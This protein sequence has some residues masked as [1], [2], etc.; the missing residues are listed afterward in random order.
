MASQPTVFHRSTSSVEGATLGQ[1][2]Q[3]HQNGSANGKQKGGGGGGGIG[4][5]K[6][7]RQPTQDT[8]SEE[9]MRQLRIDKV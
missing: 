1:D 4:K 3:Q 8:S 9:A 6:A 2:A 5:G 7:K